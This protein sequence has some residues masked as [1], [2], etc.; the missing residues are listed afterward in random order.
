MNPPD[1]LAAARDRT[2]P[3][4]DD[5][6]YVWTE[7]ET[8]QTIEWQRAQDARAV[9]DLTGW[10]GYPALREAVAPHLARQ[11]GMYAP[12]H[13]GDWWFRLGFSDGGARVEAGESPVGPS[14]VVVDPASLGGQLDWF[15]PSPDGA[16][17]A[18][19]LSSDGDEQSALHLVEV[20]TGELLAERIPF[21]SSATVAWLPDSSGFY[22]NAGTDRDD[23]DPEKRLYFHRLGD[24]SAGEAEPITIREP[25]TLF[26][27]VSADGRWLAAVAGEMDPRADL[28][29]EL[30]D[31]PWRPLLD[32]VQGRGYGVFVGDHY[33]AILTDQSPQGRVVSV[34][35]TTASDHST[36]TE[37]VPA[38]DATMMALDLVGDRLVLCELVET[39]ARLRVLRADGSDEVVV[40]LP[41]RGAVMQMSRFGPYLTPGSPWMGSCISVG[42]NEFTFVFSS[43][44]ASPALYEF[45]LRENELRVLVAAEEDRSDLVVHDRSTTAADGTILRYQVVCRRDVDLDDSTSHPTLIFGYGGFNVAFVPAYPGA[46]TA[47]VDAGGVL[48]LAHLRGGGEF[49]DTFWHQGRLT[50]KQ[51]SFDDLYATAE[52]LISSGVTSSDR[53]GLVGSSNG[54]LM[55]SVAITQRPDLW[56]AACALVPLCDMLGFVR[57][58]YTA[59]CVPEYGDPGNPAQEQVLRAYSPCHNVP[60]EIRAPATLLYCGAND[61]RCPPWHARKLTAILQDRTTSDRPIL[62]RVVADGGHQSVKYDPGQVAEWLGFL[63]RE[64]GLSPRSN[65]SIA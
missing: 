3:V 53:L 54:G 61:V 64:L 24:L 51:T 46:F 58:T 57:D 18:F 19:G 34:P 33:V 11:L 39:Y 30:P 1:P 55:V 43:P 7:V 65:R 32:G 41:G 44:T 42:T 14:R 37:I 60:A 17:V 25:A 22:Y 31:G 49:G 62:L 6:P 20:A 4:E 10:E 8:P 13:S 45:D 21:T 40:P 38:G 2:A 9:E 59:T 36:W 12:I 28:V 63:F 52:H 47:F 35:V 56:R 23:V 50:S 5:G 16:Y 15:R 29:K 27:Q 48:V 26:P